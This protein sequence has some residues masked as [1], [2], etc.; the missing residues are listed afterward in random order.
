MQDAI[1]MTSVSRRALLAVVGVV[2]GCGASSFT[3]VGRPSPS[4]CR[5]GTQPAI[6]R[7]TDDD[8]T[9]IWECL[10]S[11]QPGAEYVSNINSDGRG[12]FPNCVPQCK[13][14]WE[15]KRYF[16][17]ASL[18]SRCKMRRGECEPISDEAKAEYGQTHAECV[19][20][21]GKTDAFIRKR[22][23][24]NNCRASCKSEIFGCSSRCTNAFGP[25]TMSAQSADCERGCN[26][27]YRTCLSGCP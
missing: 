7:T 2:V 23:D 26:S 27:E 6:T 4:A 10:P 17:E 8:G 24:T 16:I 1:P 19:T 9:P 3:Q 12:V 21:E 25:S 14:G 20:D 13:P 15:R 18:E 5:S 11:C 22:A